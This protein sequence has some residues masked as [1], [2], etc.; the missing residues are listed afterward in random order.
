MRDE[1]LTRMW[2]LLEVLDQ[3]LTSTYPDWQRVRA[4]AKELLRGV[5]RA[6]RRRRLRR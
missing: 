1:E 4:A 5:R 3:E 2:D 6:M